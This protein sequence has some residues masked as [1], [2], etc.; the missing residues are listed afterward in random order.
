[1]MNKDIDKL[2]Y[3]IKKFI[4]ERQEFYIL[5]IQERFHLTYEFACI[6]RQKLLNDNIIDEKHR[7]LYSK[8]TDPNQMNIFQLLDGE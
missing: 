1:M 4:I 6:V 7:V 2:Y 3:D 5:L 8:D